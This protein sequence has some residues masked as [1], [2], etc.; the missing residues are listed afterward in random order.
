MRVYMFIC[1]NIYIYVEDCR[2]KKKNTVFSVRYL[3]I[4]GNKTD[5]FF[6]SLNTQNTRRFS[7]SIKYREKSP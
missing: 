4:F 5:P 3:N 7:V 1:I 6:F 2:V